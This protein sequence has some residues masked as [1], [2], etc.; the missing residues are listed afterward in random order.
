MMKWNEKY[1]K[2]PQIVTTGKVSSIGRQ[3]K[4]PRCAT[5]S[6]G[7][8]IINHFGGGKA[9]LNQFLQRNG[10]FYRGNSLRGHILEFELVGFVDVGGS[11]I[12]KLWDYQKIRYQRQI[13]CL[14]GGSNLK[15]SGPIGLCNWK[16]VVSFDQ[17]QAAAGASYSWPCFICGTDAGDLTSCVC[18]C[19]TLDRWNKKR[20]LWLVDVGWM[21]YV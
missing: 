19:L 10:D 12:Q 14:G 21:A 7:G 9:A 17:N 16:P 15:S 2:P 4:T 6:W 13:L 1:L 3:S 20:C 8:F 11:E 18:S 5:I